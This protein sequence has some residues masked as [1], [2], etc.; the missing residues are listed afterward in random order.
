LKKVRAQR[1]VIPLDRFSL[2]GLLTGGYRVLQDSVGINKVTLDVVASELIVRGESDIVRQVRLAMNS[3]APISSNDSSEPDL[4][5]RGRS[6]PVC[7]QNPTNPIKLSCRHA[8]CQTCLQHVLQISAGLRFTPLRCIAAMMNEE[9]EQGQQCIGN[10]PYTVV[11]DLLRADEEER[12]LKSS[13]LCHVRNNPDEYFFCP[14]PN[15]ET[16]YG[17]GREGVAYR[18]PLCSTQVCSSCHLQYHE[19]LT[20]SKRREIWAITTS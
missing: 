11:R 8:Y 6:C 10:I 2:H 16:V 20:C 15:C 17:H 9:N 12:L 1:C 3:Y 13:F 14:T 7:C 4:V 19:G 5:E 18:C